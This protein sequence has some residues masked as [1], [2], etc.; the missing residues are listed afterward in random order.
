MKEKISNRA[1]LRIFLNL[2]EVP[3]DRRDLSDDYNLRWLEAN[4]R[5]LNQHPSDKTTVDSAL[6]LIF[7]IFRGNEFTLVEVVEPIAPIPPTD[8]VG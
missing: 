5:S 4:L 2:L 8:V 3:L 6:T 7:E 1:I